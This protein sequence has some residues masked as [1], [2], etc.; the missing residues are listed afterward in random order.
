MRALM[1]PARRAASAFASR[2]AS[3][4]AASADAEAVGVEAQVGDLAHTAARARAA[5]ACSVCSA[6]AARASSGRV[7]SRASRSSCCSTPTLQV[8]RR[9]RA[10]RSSCAVAADRAP[11]RRRWRSRWPLAVPA[12]RPA[13]V[14][15]RARKP[16]SPSRSKI[17]G[18]AGAG[19]PL[20]LAV[21]VDER[22]AE[23]LG[24]APA[25]ARSCRRPSGRPGPGWGRDSW[26]TDASSR[27]HARSVHARH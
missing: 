20:D 26:R 3:R 6:V 2:C 5:S 22:Q 16:A 21:G 15:S 13:A 27:P 9:S 11:R 4:R 23:A 8:A 17:S 1:P 24:Q 19:A 14:R 25:D 7:R 18:D 10:A 12:A